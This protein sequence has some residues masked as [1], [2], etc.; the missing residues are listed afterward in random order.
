MIFF[1]DLSFFVSLPTFT[2]A[3][4]AKGGDRVRPT[5][6]HRPMYASERTYGTS[7]KETLPSL[8]PPLSFQ[9]LPSDES[10]GKR[11]ESGLLRKAGKEERE[12]EKKG[13]ITERRRKK[14]ERRRNLTVLFIL[15]FFFFFWRLCTFV[16]KITYSEEERG[17]GERKR[18]ETFGAKI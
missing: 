11:R 6:P 3:E 13:V 5:D 8:L 4:S 14:K 16:V 18:S 10:L 15:C 1:P 12:R 9:F 7:K 2:K 17:I